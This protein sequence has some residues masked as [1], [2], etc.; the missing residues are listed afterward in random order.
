MVTRIGF[1]LRVSDC[2]DPGR[3]HP[4]RERLEDGPL[5]ACLHVPQLDHP[6]PASYIPVAGYLPVVYGPLGE[7][8]SLGIPPLTGRLSLR[9]VTTSNPLRKRSRSGWNSG[10]RLRAV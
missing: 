1:F 3:G 2:H 6:V 9:S 8:V 10:K 7:V 4:L 5:L